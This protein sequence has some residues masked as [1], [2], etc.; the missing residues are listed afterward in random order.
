MSNIVLTKNN[1]VDIWN[2]IKNKYRGSNVN[3]TCISPRKTCHVFSIRH[4]QINLNVIDNG[5]DI[6][7]EMG[8][9][10]VLRYLYVI[11]PGDELCITHN[12][13]MVNRDNHSSY[14]FH[15]V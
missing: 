14:V 12:A 10:P 2:K 3:I 8:T 4:P 13:L 7:G 1:Y 11:K 9:T 6:V 5:F 15:F